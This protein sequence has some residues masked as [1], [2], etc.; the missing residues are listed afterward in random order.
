[1]EIYLVGGAVR[2]E[3]LGL[4][5]RERDWVVVGATPKVLLDLGYEQVG[6]DF[7]V[8]LHP[9]THEEYALAR[10]ERKAGPGH[11]GFETRASTDVTLSDDLKRRDLTI[12]AIAKAADGSLIDPWGGRRDLTERVLRHVSPAFAEDPLRVFR[13]ARFAARFGD[14]SVAPETLALMRRMGAAGTL[15]ELPAERVWSEL[16]RAL[17]H[18]YPA[19]F[20]AVLADC[21]GLEPWLAELA[22]A[23][24]RLSD[25]FAPLAE[26]LDRFGALGKVLAPAAADAVA[27]RLKAPGEYVRLIGQIARHGATLGSW[28]VRPAT[29]VLRAAR[30]CGALRQPAWFARVGRIIGTDLTELADAL[31]GVAAA[32]L[33]A[34][35]LDGKVLGDALDAA[36]LVAISRLAA[37]ARS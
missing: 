21:N 32:P 26:A 30:A 2:D 33:K 18:D 6:R 14:F 10:T 13:V 8:F 5:V 19:R 22:F 31:R 37:A 20:F 1:M 34:R 25:L 23:V 9:S 24:D 17:A 16:E 36:R 29:E 12:N 15:A 27:V 7:P 28:S 35:G 4:P 3:L 11:T